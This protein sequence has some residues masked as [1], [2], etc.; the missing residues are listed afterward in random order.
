MKA[1]F[2]YIGLGLSAM[3][4]AA[5]GSTPSSQNSQNSFSSLTT[6]SGSFEV[7]KTAV[8]YREETTGTDWQLTKTVT[9]SSLHLARGESGTLTYT[10]AYAQSQ[11]ASEV[12]GVRGEICV[13]NIS[14]T[15]TADLK[16]KDVVQKTFDGAGSWWDYEGVSMYVD[17]SAKPKL[18]P[19]ER[20]CY[21]YDL[22]FVPVNEPGKTF[23]YRNTVQVTSHAHSGAGTLAAPV[24]FTL[25][26]STARALTVSTTPPVPEDATLLDTLLC[27]EGFTCTPSADYNGWGRITGSGSVMYTVHV[28]NVNADCNMTFNLKNTAVL[29]PATGA[30]VDA[31][32]TVTITTPDCTVSSGCTLAQ[33]YW[34]THSKY[35]PA[36]FNN[37]WSK[38]GEDTTFFLSDQSYY[39]VINTPSAGGNAYYI[40]A[41]QYIAARLNILNG[42][43]GTEIST[44]MSEAEAFFGAH[45]PSTSLD[46]STREKVVAL[47]TTL[48]MYNEGEIGPGHCE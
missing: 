7:T 42:A 24:P 6:S 33:G 44:E 15:T 12:Y 11:G 19:G 17:T 34:R 30:S 18:A 2:R 13:K 35:G 37:T 46:A 27:P 39:Q 26:S 9:P 32:A 43:S 36:P 47:A 29:T 45:T 10:L 22:P 40:L 8:G 21:A 5:C 4:L 14:A 23:R 38:I 41:R 16:I 1:A 20:Y 48:A 28:T 25:P 31:D 3:V